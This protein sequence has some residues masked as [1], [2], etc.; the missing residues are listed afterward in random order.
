[1]ISAA[2]S[3][4]RTRRGELHDLGIGPP[5]EHGADGR[6]AHQ[7]RQQHLEARRRLGG[8][9][10]LTSLPLASI[11]TTRSCQPFSR[12]TIWWIGSTSKYSLA[13]MI[14]G[15]SGTSSMLSCQAMLRTPDSV[16]SASRAA[17]D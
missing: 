11:S 2:P 9:A 17:P 6:G 10:E 16:A 14:A 3:W 1:M 12:F 8:R 15:P 13:R 7:R 5:F 4:S